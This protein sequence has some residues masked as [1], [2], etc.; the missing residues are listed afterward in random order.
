[1]IVTD[2]VLGPSA[3]GVR[4]TTASV[5]L[6]TTLTV[7]EPATPILPPPAPE[8]AWVMK[9][10]DWSTSFW[11]VLPVPVSA[12]ALPLRASCARRG[13]LELAAGQF[14]DVVG[15]AVGQ[16]AD[17]TAAFR[18]VLHR[19]ADTQPG[20]GA[21]V[22]LYH[23]AGRVERDGA[24]RIGDVDA[25]DR[26]RL[27]ELVLGPGRPGGQVHQAGAAAS[28]GVRLG[29]VELDRSVA[30]G[31]D[32]IA[33]GAEAG[34]AA[35]R[36]VRARIVID[37]VAGLQARIEADEDGV[38]GRVDHGNRGR[39]RLDLAVRHRRLHR[40]AAGADHR[41][42]ADIGLVGDVGHVHRHRDAHAGAAAGSR[43]RAVGDR[44]AVDVGGRRHAQHAAGG[45]VQSVG[46][47]GLG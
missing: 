8:V 14:D 19:V 17:R 13:E 47:I 12:I 25:L 36:G 26:N 40:Q 3:P 41:R 37:M 5:S 10:S 23:V 27:V 21:Q 24:Q 1:M 44:M 6:L 33:V 18:V 45:D 34:Q 9:E 20:V 29:V 31:V 7:T 38:L 32:V 39:V 15:G 46:D 2:A 42:I 28:R 43:S 35:D 11:L 16:A 22:Q 4:P 30:V